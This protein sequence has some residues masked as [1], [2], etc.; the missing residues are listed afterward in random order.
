MA[1]EYLVPNGDDVSGG[2]WAT[3]TFADINNG[4]NGGTPDAAEIT[5]GD[6]EGLDVNLD[7]V[8][9]AIADGDTVNSVTIRVRAYTLGDTDDNLQVNLIVGGSPVGTQQET[10]HLAGSATTY[11]MVDAVG[12]DVDWT[13]AQLDGMQVRLGTEQGGKPSTVDI[14]VTEVEVE[15]DWTAGA[16]DNTEEPLLVELDLDSTGLEP[17][18][19]V[20]NLADMDTIDT[21]VLAGVLPESIVANVA[22]MDTID[23]LVLG[24]AGLEPTA[25]IATSIEVSTGALNIYKF[26]GLKL[27]SDP[28]TATVAGG[29][30]NPEEPLLGE[31]DLAGIVPTVVTNHVTKPTLATLALGVVGNDLTIQHNRLAELDTIDTLVLA[32]ILP[33]SIVGNNIEVPTKALVLDGSNVPISAVGNVA[34]P[35]IDELVLA[36]IV[37]TLDITVTPLV[38]SLAL[39]TD[40]L[41]PFALV[42]NV[43]EPAIDEL[44]LGQL[45]PTL[46]HNRLADVPIGALVL[47]T[48]GLDP[49]A[50]VGFTPEPSTIG[51]VLDSD[52]LEPLA[53]VAHN[54]EVPLGELDLASVKP[55]VTSGLTPLPG[56]DTLVLSGIA[57]EAIVA[58]TREPATVGLVLGELTPTIDITVSPLVG[59]LV[60]DGSNV[61][62]SVVANI[63]EPAIGELVF[64]SD[65][66]DV[67][68]GDTPQPDS[69]ALTLSGILPESIVS[70]VTLPTAIGLSLSGAAPESITA[71][72]ENPDTD[73]LVLAGLAPTVQHNRLADVDTIDTLVLSGKVPTLGDAGTVLLTP[74]RPPL[75][76]LH[77]AG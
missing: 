68:S 46:Q 2:D 63:R 76:G 41:D 73:A 22:A 5:S 28:P 77:L 60:L 49:V 39:D 35:A 34:I 9:S 17:L 45:T 62:I 40:A 56:E 54:I 37:P 74:Y 44:V 47:D 29:G 3:G 6:G 18:A 31:L 65:A 25:A 55:E 57:P 33:E 50:S 69:V 71:N 30:D 52:G 12:W 20:A 51:L 7:L 24:T 15:V 36:G 32:G 13:A 26:I 53:V 21:L 67:T 11:T 75:L 8:D 14:R 1:T 70:N 43:R 64:A 4:I 38:G 58:N 48:D 10:G 72:P 23:T 27:D 66:P 59:A 61:P 16:S 19:V 42:G